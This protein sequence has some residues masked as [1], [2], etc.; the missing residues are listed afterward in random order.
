MS[1]S[2]LV[3]GLIIN[4]FAGVGGSVALKGSDGKATREQ[5]LKLGAT[6]KAQ[7]RVTQALTLLQPQ[8][9]A[10]EFVTCSG[11][12][13]ADVL[14]QLG[15]SYRTVFTPADTETSAQDT[16]QAVAAIQAEGVDL[17]LF[18]GGDGTARDVYEVIDDEQLVLGIPAGVKIH[19]GVYAVSPKAAGRVVE[20]IVR[21]ELSSLKRADVMDIDEALFRQGTVKARRYGDM[22]IPAELEYVQA[23]KMG[24]IE[25]DELVLAD[26]AAEV[27]ERVDDEYLVMGSGSTVAAVMEEM[28]LENTLLGVDLVHDQQLLG[29]DLTEQQLYQ[30][31]ANIE[32]GKVKLVITV[33]GGQGHVLGRGN[34]QLSPRIL[35]HIGRENVWLVATKSKLESLQGRPL[36]L[37]SGDETLDQEWSGLIAVITGYHDEVLVRLQGVA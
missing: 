7:Q 27:I 14:R 22:L 28:G 21:G 23:V 5:A 31:V 2:R 16:Q 29:S 35:R 4:P 32:P 15:F 6:P 3:V 17:L 36:L 12:M 18:A 1:T 26:I 34:Q 9:E 25:S 33:I 8:Q 37:D 13:G 20:R 19:S 11:A 24:G 30:Q 10:L